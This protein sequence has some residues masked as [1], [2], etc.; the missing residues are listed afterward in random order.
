MHAFQQGS[1]LSCCV[2]W[3]R[4]LNLSACRQIQHRVILQPPFLTLLSSLHELHHVH[5]SYGAYPGSDVLSDIRL[6]V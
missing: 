4:C 1:N 5:A 2:D 6:T 3:T